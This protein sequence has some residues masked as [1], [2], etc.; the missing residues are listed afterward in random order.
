MSRI[1][2]TLATPG[3]IFRKTV[4]HKLSNFYHFND[5]EYSMVITVGVKSWGFPLVSG[6]DSAG[7]LEC[8][9]LQQ[10]PP[11]QPQTVKIAVLNSPRM[12]ALSSTVFCWRTSPNA[13]ETARV[14]RDLSR[15]TNS[16]ETESLCEN[17]RLV[18]NSGPDPGDRR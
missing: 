14:K 4:F 2:E 10:L 12:R 3:E 11:G 8:T 13:N 6:R 18:C 17:S 15:Q 7:I 9:T 16:R 5:E 1:V